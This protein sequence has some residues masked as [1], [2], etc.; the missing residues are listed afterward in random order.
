MPTCA[1]TVPCVLPDELAAI[2]ERAPQWRMPRSRA[3]LVTIALG[4]EGRERFTVAYEVPGRGEV[5]EA[6]VVRSKNGVVVNYLEPYMRRRDPDCMVVADELPTDQPTFASRFGQPFEPVRAAVHAWLATQPLLVM[7]FWAGDRSL[8]H[9]ALLIAPLN[10]G[11][12]AAAL[13]DLQGFIPADQLPPQFTPRAVILVAPPFRHTLCQGRQVVVHRRTA[14]LHEMYSL[15]LYPGPS[16]KKG[17][18][19]VLLHIGEREGWVTVHGATVQV[20]TPYDNT[21][22][23]LHEGASGGGK[24][25]MLEYAHREHDGQLLLGTNVVTGEVR[26]L[27]IP[28]GC[29]LRP[30][31]DDMALCHPLAQ[32]Q[33]RK[34]V[35][36]DAEDAWF[37]RVNHITRYGTDHQLEQLTIH[38]PE[39]L[40]FL[41]IQGVPGATT[42]IWEHTEDKPGVR[43]PNP[44]VILPRRIVPD[45]V[46]GTVEVDVRSFG[47]RCPPC[48]AKLPTYG[49]LGIFHVLPPALAWLWRLVAPRGHANPSIVGE[50]GL[51][52]EGVGS[53]WPF[54]T[55]RRIDQANLLLRQIQATPD[56]RY[57]LVPN[58]HVGAWRMGFMPQ[59]LTREYLARRGGVRFDKSQLLPARCPLLGWTPARLQIEGVQLPNWL[60]RVHDQPEVGEAAYDHGARIFQQFFAQV[61][62]AY[63]TAELDPLGQRIIACCL[64]GGSVS[65]Y[66]SLL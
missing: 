26:H 41:N 11:F 64:D 15:N 55:G 12:F 37:V 42:L 32:G 4:G 36:Q 66:E 7:P 49:I 45:I 60:L 13:A 29:R 51:A 9:G 23:I 21:V 22:T 14:Q 63:R 50:D 46:D 18:Y 40:V 20:V 56:T 65:D 25:E 57:I 35:V 16:A 34:L 54:A 39:P 48:T 19:G 52:S 62:A 53:Y 8:G 17:V 33:K 24:S 61:L 2:L 10:A 47:V 31:T 3:E 59:W 30:V 28:Q 43:C 44:R 5:A 27:R 6:E 1:P 58:Q 38:A